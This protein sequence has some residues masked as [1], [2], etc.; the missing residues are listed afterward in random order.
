MIYGLLQRQTKKQYDPGHAMTFHYTFL[1]SYGRMN[2]R[3][4]E[5]YMILVTKMVFVFLLPCSI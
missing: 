3:T 5:L 1:V 4:S 2:R